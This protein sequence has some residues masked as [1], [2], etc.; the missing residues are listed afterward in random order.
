[1]SEQFAQVRQYVY[2]IYSQIACF[3]QDLKYI[4]F[5]TEDDIDDLSLSWTESEDAGSD[6]GNEIEE[7]VPPEEES[8]L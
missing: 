5:N 1:M 7:P 2:F 6:T 8:T 4:L 3:F